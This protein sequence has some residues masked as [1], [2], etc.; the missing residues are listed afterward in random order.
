[1]SS[2][3]L[4]LLALALLAYTVASNL[5]MARAPEAPATVALV[6]GPLVLG[7]LAFA[8]QSRPGRLALGLAL[9]AG[10]W[11]WRAGHFD[12]LQVSWLY[13][14]QHVGI[15]AML[16]L[17]FAATLRPG[18]TALISQLARRVHEQFTPAMADYT[19]RLTLAWALLF[20]LLGGVSLLLFRLGSYSTWAFWAGAVTPAAYAVFFV[21]EHVLR[22]VRHP[23]FE[24]VSLA[25]ALR[26][27]HEHE[28]AGR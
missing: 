21:G 6:L 4:A 9:A 10:V 3:R 24:R 18:H 13:L 26:S 16:G 14:I 5:A 11:A 25:R 1:M 17:S 22:Y 15:Q 19:R 2:T 12:A 7:L 27:W 28:Q 20:A 8:W 23:E